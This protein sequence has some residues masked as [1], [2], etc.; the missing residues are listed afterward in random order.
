MQSKPT[1]P[2][3]WIPLAEASPAGGECHRRCG[4][5]RCLTGRRPTPLTEGLQAPR[6]SLPDSE[7]FRAKAR[8][9]YLFTRRLA[10]EHGP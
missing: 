1:S 8:L 4:F 7:S 9:A 3:L 2:N 6:R 10:F 5:A